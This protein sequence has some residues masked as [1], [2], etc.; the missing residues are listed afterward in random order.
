MLIE[1]AQLWWSKGEHELATKL[2]KDITA[3]RNVSIGFIRACGLYGEYL[4]ETTQG[5]TKT[6][7][8]NYLKESV[9]L[10]HKYA[11]LN[12]AQSSALHKTE[13]ERQDFNVANKQR[14]YRAIAKCT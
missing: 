12:M 3:V 2:M 9:K 5:N 14:N 11:E 4:A 7:I 6:I 8:E 13:R 10:S 1:E